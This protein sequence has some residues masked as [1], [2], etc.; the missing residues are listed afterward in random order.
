MTSTSAIEVY[1]VDPA[2]SRFT[3]RA[4]AT[5]MFSALGHSP[6]LAVRDFEGLATFSLEALD[7]ARLMI[8]IKAGSLSLT[9]NVSDKDRKELERTMNLEV[10]ETARYPEIVFESTKT[11]ASKAGDHQFFVNLVG[12]LTLRGVTNTQAVNA[13]VAITGDILHAHGEFNVSQRA[14]GIKPVSVAG[15]AIKLK[16]ELKCSFDIVARK[17]GN[18]A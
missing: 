6:T 10:L 17:K 5:G 8:K 7:D 14:F 9:D 2:V 18:N 3:V 1:A 11:A 15:G 16:D 12:T 13:Q 4:F